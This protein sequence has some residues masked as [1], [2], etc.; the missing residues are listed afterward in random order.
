MPKETTGCHFPSPAC[1]PLKLRQCTAQWSLPGT[2]EA[3]M[4]SKSMAASIIYDHCTIW[5]SPL[6]V[7]SGENRVKT[8][9]TGKVIRV[10]RFAASAQALLATLSTGYNEWHINSRH[11]MNGRDLLSDEVLCL[12]LEWFRE[13]RQ[14]KYPSRCCLF[15]LHQ[16]VS[17]ENW[18]ISFVSKGLPHMRP[19]L[20][21]W[22]KIVI[23]FLLYCT[24]L[25][26]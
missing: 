4:W 22:R 1:N 2:M 24:V 18:K 5:S 13:E 19:S 25:E 20:C 23:A 3:Y 12:S 11:K 9:A 16:N 14:S 6:G 21:A 15:P 10:L 17:R 8:K 26:S 7:C